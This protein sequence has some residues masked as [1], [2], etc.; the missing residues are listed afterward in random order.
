MKSLD[1]SRFVDKS[2]VRAKP[3]VFYFC[4]GLFCMLCLLMSCSSSSHFA[5]VIDLSHQAAPPKTRPHAA[6]RAFSQAKPPHAIRASLPIALGWVWPTQGK[7]LRLFSAANKGIDI[8]GRRG[9]P[10]C[11]AASGTVVYSGR[12]KH[13]KGSLL[14][15]KHSGR[16]SSS[17]AYHQAAWVKKGDRVK[18]GQIIAEMGNTGASKVMLH[19]EIRRA[20]KPID[21][22]IVYQGGPFT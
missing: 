8:A 2:C 9:E 16:Y 14:I 11:A 4:M 13:G 22:V 17:Y 6:A 1:Q 15:I 10:I 7:V 21:P 3:A 18:K 20:G 5:P 19:F 12:A